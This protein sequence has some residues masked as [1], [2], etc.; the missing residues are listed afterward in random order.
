MSRDATI[1]KEV[2]AL[3]CLDLDGLRDAWRHRFGMA[4]TIR[5]RDLLLRMLAFEIQADSF[6][7][8]AAELRQQLR[9]AASSARPKVELQAGTT[10]IR[11]WRGERHVVQVTEAGFEHQGTTHGSLSE[12]AR[13][14]TGTRCSG[15][16]FFGLKD[17]ERTKSA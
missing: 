15:P 10:I 9:R 16:R 11:E 6:G 17:A 5:S 13:E 2:G 3:E 12:L 1:G 8:L 14:I 4:P 7:G